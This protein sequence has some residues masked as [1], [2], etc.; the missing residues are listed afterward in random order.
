[1]TRV[2]VTS[3]GELEVAA[4]AANLKTS[5]GQVA[6]LRCNDTQAQALRS[7]HAKHFLDSWKRA[8]QTVVGPLV[9]GAEG[10]DQ[11]G[12]ESRVIGE[13]LDLLNERHTDLRHERLFG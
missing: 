5:T 12:L 8:H 2:L 1:M 6:S 13:V 9:V 10:A 11:I 4:Q 3:H 7:Q